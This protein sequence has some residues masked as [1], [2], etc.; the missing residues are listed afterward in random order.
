MFHYKA[1]LKQLLQRFCSHPHPQ[2]FLL[3]VTSSAR[4]LRVAYTPPSSCRAG[5]PPTRLSERRPGAAPRAPGAPTASSAGGRRLNRAGRGAGRPH[6]G[7]RAAFLPQ[8]RRRGKRDGGARGRAGAAGTAPAAGCLRPY[9][10]GRGAAAERAGA[11]PAAGR[12]P[13]ARRGSSTPPPPP[14]GRC[15][16]RRGRAATPALTAPQREPPA[17]HRRAAAGSGHLWP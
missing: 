16:W 12:S 13:P 6:R 1:I 14:P 5:G 3:S 4:V 17:P 9:P 11:G 15:P 10:V 2:C 7:Q 8:G